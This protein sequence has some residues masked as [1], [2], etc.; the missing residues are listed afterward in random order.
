MSF[1]S[2]ANP[3]IGSTG[4]SAGGSRAG[5]GS[6]TVP[7]LHCR[8]L[9][10]RYGDL[11]AVDGLD[12][13]VAAGECF[14]LLGP[15]GAG[16][17]TTVELFEGLLSPDGGTLEV[18]GLRWKGDGQRL[19]ARL[20]VQLQET[21]FPEKLRVTELVELFR[22]F[23]RD[24][25]PPAAALALVG[26]E[27]K[28]RAFVRELSGGQK[29]R[30][31][32]ACALVGD[33]EVLFLDEPTTGLDPAS[34]RQIW[35]I[36]ERLKE[37]G[38]TV[39]L[40]THYMEEAARLCDRVAIIDRGRILAEGAPAVLVASL[41]AEHVIEV[42]TESEIPEAALAGLPGV[43]AIRRDGTTVRLTVR[44]VHRA[45]PPLLARLA[46][47]HIEARRLATHH[48]TLE[49]LF[50]ALTGRTLEGGSAVVASGDAAGSAA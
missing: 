32:L 35:E 27:E 40:T 44:E 29:Q 4:G 36:V 15:N 37:R 41:G 6:P 21:R 48:A 12:L 10:K 38:R 24:G 8:G 50:I 9:V 34:R 25:L 5:S 1:G 2:A 22:S 20:G 49:D 46:E 23:Y 19:R 3:A 30:L 39:L 33:P 26:L 7:A 17:T 18:L 42:E 31:S 16:K 47:R 13:E 43:E 28:R 45:V 14:G 11:V